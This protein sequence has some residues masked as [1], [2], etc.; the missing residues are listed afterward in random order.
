MTFTPTATLSSS[1]VS[2]T[3]PAQA[4]GK[5]LIYGANY[6]GTEGSGC[7]TAVSNYYYMAFLVGTPA[8]PV[9]TAGNLSGTA[10]TAIT[11]FTM[12]VT[13]TPTSYSATGL[14]AG[15][16]IDTTSGV[17][18][19]TPTAAGTFSTTV[20]ATNA[21]GS[22]SATLSSTIAYG[23]QSPLSVTST[24]GSFG[25]DLALTTSG[26]SGAGAVSYAVTTA[27]TAGCSV[28][29][30]TLRFTAIGT[31]AVTAT[32]AGD[33]A[34][35][36]RASSATT[37]TAT[38]GTPSITWSAPQS[39]SYPAMISATQ[40]NAVAR[41]NG[42]PITGTLTYSPASG[43]QLTPGTH[44]LS[45][46]FAPNDT[47]NV[48]SVPVTTV[49]I[50][51]SSGA[52]LT[53]VLSAAT[54]VAGGF[55]STVLNY[56]AD[57]SWNVNVSAGSVALDPSTHV[58]TVS[59]LAAGASA[60]VTVTAS[61]ANYTMGSVIVSAQALAVPVISS[62]TTAS[63]EVGVPFTGYAIAASSS[64][65]SYSASGLPAPL[66][67]DPQTGVISG[68][69]Q[70]AGTYT[71]TLGAS[72]AAGSGSRV[73]TLTVNHGEQGALTMI[74]QVGTYGVPLVLAATGGSGT[75]A[76]NFALG[77]AGTAGC[78]L[79]GQVLTSAQ[80]GTCTIQ[81]SKA[82]DADFRDK[83]ALV[84]V[85]IGRI[86]QSTLVITSSN[87]KGFDSLL[88][89]DAQGGDGGGAITYAI[90]TPGTAGCSISGSS[91]STTGDVGS[92]C[93]ITATRAQSTNY[94]SQASPEQVVTVTT[95]AA[96]STLTI[97]SSG[98]GTYRTPLVLAAT[99]G[100][101]TGSI[102][103]SVSTIGSANC[104]IVNGQ[105]LSTGVLGTTCGIVAERAESVNY[106]AQL[107]AEQIVTVSQR[108]TQEI[109]FPQPAE[110]EYSPTPARITAESDSQLTVTFSS[111]T[112]SVCTIS[113]HEVLPRSVGT[114]TLVASQQ[115]DSLF[116]AASD[117]VRTFQV[118]RVSPQINWGSIPDRTYGHVLTRDSIVSTSSI[119]GVFTYDV[120]SEDVLPVGEYLVTMTFTPTDQ[121][122]YLPVTVIRHFSILP[123]ATA[124]WWAPRTTLAGVGSTFAISGATASRQ[125]RIEYV[126]VGGSQSCSLDVG[127]TLILR[128]SELGPCS[129]RARIE[130]TPTHVA[131]ESYKTFRRADAAL[132]SAAVGSAGPGQSAR[133]GVPSSST[134]PA[135]H[136]ARTV[137]RLPP[138]PRTV[139]VRQLNSS[140]TRVTAN[141]QRTIGSAEIDST[142]IEIRDASGDRVSRSVITSTGGA[143]PIA[144]TVPRL[145]RG[146]TVTAFNVNRA[147]VSRRASFG[148]NLLRRAPQAAQGP[149]MGAQRGSL[150]GHALILESDW[151]GVTPRQQRWLRKVALI[152]NRDSAPLLVTSQSPT[153][154]PAAR[155]IA[156]QRALDVCMELMRAGLRT[157]LT[158]APSV[159]VGRGADDGVTAVRVSR[160]TVPKLRVTS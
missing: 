37:I 142:V 128:M 75:G 82:G 115:G 39:I 118:V 146:Y 140:T 19:G 129:V 14:P 49:S 137:L 32:K 70:N 155:A 47:A 136:Q 64:P 73:L 15:L 57:F 144:V 17:I 66:V 143:T 86:P 80:A 122:T 102:S 5:Y 148:A 135:T 93:G 132:A 42:T 2:G 131:A 25:T 88:S 56:D 62:S 65:T 153:S 108:S 21:G 41:L 1:N 68:V 52:A 77:N 157:W 145:R 149:T 104:S 92:T 107:S 97:S 4:A 95:K 40:L 103:F 114:C 38:K 11:A 91:L 121:V 67:L 158:C 134:T 101:G 16:Q 28:S 26:G 156:R 63:A 96:Q 124:L 147:G 120:P 152:A 111:S 130:A 58:V 112:P 98:S 138:A 71:V 160:G 100:S 76:V 20:T 139:T 29:G 8:A 72:N 84:Q 81:V 44:T 12:S 59:G 119:A 109:S 35:S 3:I 78:V 10:G 31:C 36:S 9:V 30:S 89:L 110:M 133:P 113:G 125:G 22:G 6:Q 150:V 34:Y 50:T 23:T 116:F 48:N 18:S 85:E 54:I 60:S 13:N 94:L 105:L 33:S 74:T 51:V 43:T 61:R 83:S 90:T 69:P 45:V 151:S 53:P 141:Q 55:T 46:A 117:V 126:V 159:S 87:A 27:G 154:S 7:K 106:L 123:E 24:S 127:A 99:G 79:A